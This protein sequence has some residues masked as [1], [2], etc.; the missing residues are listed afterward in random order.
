MQTLKQSVRPAAGGAIAGILTVS[1]AVSFALV[2]SHAHPKLAPAFGIFFQSLLL[3]TVFAQALHSAFHTLPWIV[4]CPSSTATPFGAKMVQIA[5]AGLLVNSQTDSDEAPIATLEAAA[6]RGLLVLACS[7]LVMA[8][9]FFLMGASAATAERLDLLKGSFPHPLVMGSFAAVGISIVQSGL[10]LASESGELDASQIIDPKLVCALLSGLIMRLATRSKWGKSALTIPLLLLGQV[11]LFWLVATMV[12]GDASSA[13]VEARKSGWLFAEFAPCSFQHF[14]EVWSTVGVHI[15]DAPTS[16]YLASSTLWTHIATLIPILVLDLLTGVVVPL[17]Q[18]GQTLH[19]RQELRFAATANLM[20]AGFGSGATYASLSPS[21]LFVEVSGSPTPG[22]E[23]TA[24]LAGGFAAVLIPAVALTPLGPAAVALCP[25]FLVSGLLVYLGLGYIIEGL[26][27]PRRLLAALAPVE[28]GV[29]IITMVLSIAV[30]MLQAMLIGLLLLSFLFVLRYGQSDVVYFASSAKHVPSLR[31]RHYH[32]PQEWDALEPMLSRI[33]VVHARCSHLFFGSVSAIMAAAAPC[34]QEGAQSRQFLILNLAEVRTVDSSAIAALTRVPP[35]VTILLVELRADLVKLLREASV[36][37]SARCFENLDI[38]M[39]YCEDQ[40]LNDY[41]SGSKFPAID[42]DLSSVSTSAW[43]QDTRPG[44]L[45]RDPPPLVPAIG[46]REIAETKLPAPLPDENVVN[47]LATS[48]QGASDELLETLLN[49]RHSSRI[50]L[51]RGSVIA[52]L[53]SN[54]EG[55]IVCL[56]GVLGLYSSSVRLP[57]LVHESI[58]MD[59]LVKGIVGPRTLAT[60]TEQKPPGMQ[61]SSSVNESGRQCSVGP[62]YVCGEASL[63]V[64]NVVRHRA[65]LIA[66]TECE[67]LLV[68]RELMLVLEAAVNTQWLAL[69]LHR[70]LARRLYAEEIHR[71]SEQ[72]VMAPRVRTMSG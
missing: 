3:S 34:I 72:D 43:P 47:I 31:S 65:S 9:F 57:D 18:A 22:A 68:R 52:E 66:E 56:R 8:L 54:C 55:M 13:E 69:E 4:A 48:L 6:V 14:F 37:K 24:R 39:Q 41:F 7:S 23:T 61:G 27:D 67:C 63:L 29:I 35:L 45:G 12:V 15:R 30:G 5:V 19:C 2:L 51:V 28:Y 32:T 1:R 11:P 36:L 62:G 44:L 16:D 20:A 60:G 38:A 17:E 33:F 58:G 46:C 42:A 21:R 59:V 25:R 40:L 70:C 50:A 64:D 49:G 10:E 53:G 26:W 71:T